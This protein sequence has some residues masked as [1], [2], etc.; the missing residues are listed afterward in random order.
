MKGYS[1]D[2]P[3]NC[4][5]ARLEDVNASYKDLSEVCGRIRNKKTKWALS[6]L[7]QASLGE[8]PVLYKRHNKRLGHRKEL[9]G[10]R[11]RYPKKAAKIILKVLESA[12][13]NGKI[14]GLGDSYNII[15]AT[16]NKKHIYPRMASKGRSAR[17]N[18]VTSRIE[19]V[20]KG[21]DVPKGVV[22]T[23]PKK[24]EHKK[25]ESTESH[26]PMH[27][28]EGKKKEVEIKSDEKHKLEE[29][30]NAKDKKHINSD[31]GRKLTQKTGD[32]N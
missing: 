21:S 5:R 1:S 18:L 26:E 13:A 27:K 2:I 28:E 8:I 22:V 29:K 31:S 17:S 4:A 20:L 24:P 25:I 16:A 30:G 19:L 3:E 10:Q 7:E 15:V 23:S 14:K 6:F 9:G 12:I 11:G 32:I